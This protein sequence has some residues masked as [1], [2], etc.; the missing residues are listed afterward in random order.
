MF[1][2]TSVSCKQREEDKSKDMDIQTGYG[3]VGLSRP[4]YSGKCDALTIV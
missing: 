3:R 2:T 1:E 4:F